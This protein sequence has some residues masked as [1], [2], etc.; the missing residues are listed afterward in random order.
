MKTSITILFVIVCILKFNAQHYT[1]EIGVF[2]GSTSLQSDYGQRGHFKSE[3][4]NTDL[5]FS[6]SHYL[7]FYN[8]TLRWDP[9]N[10]LHN[11]LMVK[12]ELQYIK[13]TNL[14]HVGKWAEK[15]SIGGAKLRAMKGSVNMFNV[16]INLEYFLNPL[17]EFIYPHSDMLLNPFFTFGVQYS[18]YNNDLKSDLGD[19]TQDP[20]VLPNKYQNPNHL[21]IGKGE[22]FAFN[23][24]IG[25][26]I[27]ITEDLD[28]VPQANYIY[29]LTDELD[30]LIADVFENRN[31]E[32]AFNFQI[33]LI[34][35][36]NYSYPLFD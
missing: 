18:F 27:K 36:L 35:H 4:K 6:V 7:S 14:E 32:W 31:N 8:R 13:S 26:R 10:V 25:T 21:S 9:N 28:L 29:F 19:W 30:G 11:H 2:V 1:H 34:Y 24:G 5:S 23:V 12:T 3:I 20:S 33:G 16:G 17:E 15:Q 22:T